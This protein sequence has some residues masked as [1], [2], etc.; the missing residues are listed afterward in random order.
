MLFQDAQVQQYLEELWSPLHDPANWS[1]HKHMVTWNQQLAYLKH[2]QR[3]KSMESQQLDLLERQLASLHEDNDSSDDYAKKIAELTDRIK[4]IRGWRHHR[5]FLCSRVT[6]LKEGQALTAYFHKLFRKRQAATR[7]RVLQTERGEVLDD[8]ELILQEFPSYYQRLYSGYE[9]GD[10]NLKSLQR[11][12][13][14][15]T[16]C[17]LDGHTVEAQLTCLFKTFGGLD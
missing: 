16:R 6:T 15:L 17:E 5:A 10:T 9:L 7:F 13:D 12:L 14:Q 11:V 4:Q 8:P 1:L 2:R 3:E